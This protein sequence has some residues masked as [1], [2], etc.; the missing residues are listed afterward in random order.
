LENHRSVLVFLLQPS[1][2]LC[3][4]FPLPDAPP[5][6]R[7]PCVEHRPPQAALNRATCRPNARAAASQPTLACSCLSTSHRRCPS[8]HDSRW[9]S[10]PVSVQPRLLLDPEHLLELPTHSFLPSRDYIPTTFSSPEHHPSS[11]LRHSLGPPSSA[12]LTVFEPRSSAIRALPRPNGAPQPIQFHSPALEHRL[13]Q[14][15]RPQAPPPLGLA[16]DPTPHHPSAPTKSTSRTTSSYR[17]DPATPSLPNNTPTSRTP[18]RHRH[19]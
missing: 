14:R 1:A 16:V 3:S 10:A 12:A 18:C 6:L 19:R 11:D 8:R 7:R 17:S 2:L 15:R 5:P 9:S 13:P 4:D